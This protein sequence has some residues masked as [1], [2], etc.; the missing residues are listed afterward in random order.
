MYAIQ[1]LP[2]DERQCNPKKKEDVFW[3]GYQI[4]KVAQLDDQLP[5][6]ANF[7]NPKMFWYGERTSLHSRGLD[8]SAFGIVVEDERIRKLRV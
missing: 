5:H 1:R 6:P 3:L 2:Y 7:A 8:V 4:G